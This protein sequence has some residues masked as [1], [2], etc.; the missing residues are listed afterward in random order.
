M[1]E[2]KIPFNQQ[3]DKISTFP[4]T[5]SVD[6]DV[7]SEES[8]R[9]EDALANRSEEYRRRAR[10]QRLIAQ[11]VRQVQESQGTK[12]GRNL[13]AEIEAEEESEGAPKRTLT[14]IDIGWMLCVA[15]FFDL[16]G[17]LISLIDAIA[18]PV[19]EIINGVTVFPI[20]AT[21]LYFMYKKRGVEFKDTKVLVRFWGS[22]L[23]GFIPII[24]V[25]PEY[26]LNVI[27]VS[28]GKKAEE[29]LEI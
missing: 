5:G 24:A 2:E 17:G 8:D 6:G 9:A 23:I 19:G 11:R 1:A 12:L 16:I 27:L 20:A 18:P 14:K 13:Q 29:K 7:I 15:A 3:V 10:R 4:R 25:F 28:I 26:M 21:T 22:L